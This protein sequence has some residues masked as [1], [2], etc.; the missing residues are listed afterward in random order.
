M[1][2]RDRYEG[3]IDCQDPRTLPNRRW[4]RGRA[5]VDVD[6]CS[7]RPGPPIPGFS[8]GLDAH[9]PSGEGGEGRR[10]EGGVIDI[11]SDGHRFKG[12][13]VGTAHEG[14]QRQ[15]ITMTRAFCLPERNNMFTDSAVGNPVLSWKVSYAPDETCSLH[16]DCQIV[17]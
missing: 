6:F 14:H 16:V 7:R 17:G 11:S 8:Q 13:A 10:L 2:Y 12:G 1:S 4:R 9:I 3:H 15:S 5:S